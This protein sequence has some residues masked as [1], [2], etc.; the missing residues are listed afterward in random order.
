MQ[1]PGKMSVEQTVQ[2]AL[3]TT[4]RTLPAGPLMKPAARQPGRMRRINRVI[5]EHDNNHGKGDAPSEQFGRPQHKRSETR[6]KGHDE[7]HK[8]IGHYTEGPGSERNPGPCPGPFGRL[9]GCL[10]I[11]GKP[12]GVD[13]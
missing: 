6:G 13:L 7:Q 4:G 5:E 1:G 2:G 10:T 11:A 8:Q 12:G 3:P 9:T